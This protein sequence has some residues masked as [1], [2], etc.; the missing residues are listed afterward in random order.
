VAFW[1]VYYSIRRPEGG[2]IALFSPPAIKTA[3]CVSVF[4]GFGV[5]LKTI[6]MMYT[7]HPAYLSVLLLTDSLVIVLYHR[8]T[9][10]RDEANIRD[11]LGVVACAIVLVVVTRLME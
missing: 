4:S 9:G 8:L 1:S 10:H 2:T 11:G 3:A 5:V 7:P 6:A